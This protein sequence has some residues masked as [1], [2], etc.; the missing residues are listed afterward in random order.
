MSHLSKS[1]ILI[2]LQMTDFKFTY[3]FRCY[4]VNFLQLFYMTYIGRTPKLTVVFH[5]S[6]HQRFIQT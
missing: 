4:S 1:I 5:N 6:Y 3:E 2:F